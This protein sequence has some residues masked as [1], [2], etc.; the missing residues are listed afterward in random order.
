MNPLPEV[1]SESMQGRNQPVVV[2]VI[3]FFLYHILLGMCRCYKGTLV[4]VSFAVV[5]STMMSD[6]LSTPTSVVCTH[7]KACTFSNNFTT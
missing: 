4:G 3:G 1:P 7:T 2:C 6:S 5:L